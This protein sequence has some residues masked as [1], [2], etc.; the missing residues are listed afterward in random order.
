MHVLFAFGG[1]SN[2]DGN[3]RGVF[4]GSGGITNG[5]KFPDGRDN[6][7]YGVNS[8]FWVVCKNNRFLCF[9]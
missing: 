8:S 4:N 5:S 7:D 9:D 2:G 6:G 1:I 3:G